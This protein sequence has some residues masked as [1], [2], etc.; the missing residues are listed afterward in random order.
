MPPAPFN[1][2]TWQ[3]ADEAHAEQG[4][5]DEQD[6]PEAAAFREHTMRMRSAKPTF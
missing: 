5:E 2:H 3:G 6:R 4:N 1:S